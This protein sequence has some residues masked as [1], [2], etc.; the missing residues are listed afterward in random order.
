MKLQLRQF[1]TLN[2]AWGRAPTASPCCPRRSFVATA[3]AQA[4]HNKWSKTKHIKAVT[5]KKKM[6]A[7]TSFEK[8]IAMHSRLNGEDLKFNP[9]LASAITAANKASVPKSIIEGAIARGQGRSTTGARLEPMQLEVLLPPDVAII[10]EAETDNKNRTLGDLR[11]VV[12]KAGALTS[13]TNFYFTKRGRAV[14]KAAAA[15]TEGDAGSSGGGPDLSE[16]VDAAIELEGVEDAEDMPDGSFLVWTEPSK[17]ASITETLSRQLN[18]D[19]RESDIVWHPN[20][21]TRVEIASSEIVEVLEILLSGIREYPE[22]KGVFANVCQ[23]SS[24]TDDEWDRIQRYL[25]VCAR[26]FLIS[27]FPRKG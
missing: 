15:A 8:L 6:V 16:L 21:D 1:L 18:L 13:S 7:R 27:S 3:C 24:I 17:L 5:D 19:V 12:K 2:G 25:D 23:G 20:E 14:F 26:Y 22:V 9:Q 4:G 10:V 11:V